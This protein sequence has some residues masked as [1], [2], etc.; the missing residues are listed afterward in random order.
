M[1]IV[2]MINDSK[3]NSIEQIKNFL[4]EVASIEFSKRSRKETYCWIEEN[5]QRFNYQIINFH[6]DNGFRIA[7]SD[8]RWWRC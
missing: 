6:A 1:M 7:Q 3:V 4:S 2:I 5:L 8:R